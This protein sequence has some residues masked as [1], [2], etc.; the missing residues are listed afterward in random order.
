M[1]FSEDLYLKSPLS[2]FLFCQANVTRG[3]E[4]CLTSYEYV[5]SI[6]TDCWLCGSNYE[7]SIT[8][9]LLNLHNTA[10]GRIHSVIGRSQW[11]RGLRRRSA[12][13]C[14]CCDVA[15][16]RPA[17]SWVHHTTSCNTQSSAPAYGHNNCLKHVELARIINKTLLLHLVGCLYYLYFIKFF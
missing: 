17:T 13:A 3:S 6:T 8:L 12:V 7:I 1:T 2:R 5:S 4:V 15:G 11:A 10:L 14:R 16:H 9:M